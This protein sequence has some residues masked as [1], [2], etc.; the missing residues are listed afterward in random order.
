MRT[1]AMVGLLWIGSLPI[2]VLPARA[3]V[4]GGDSP[5]YCTEKVAITRDLT[6]TDRRARLPDGGANC[7]GPVAISNSM[8]ALAALG[9]P[10][11][12]PGLP[13]E[14]EA[15]RAVARTLAGDGYTA[16]GSRRGTNVSR[17]I[18][19]ANRY[20]TEQGYSARF[21]FQGWRAVGAEHRRGQY[22]D[23]QWIADRLPGPR[24]AWFNIGWYR[25]DEET[26]TYHRGGGHWV[27]AVGYGID[28]RG[29]L[30]PNILIIYDPSPRSGYRRRAD[31]VRWHRLDSGRLAGPDWVPR[32]PGLAR[33]LL[34]LGGG[35][36]INRR[37]GDTALLDGVL[38]MTLDPP[39]DGARRSAPSFD[40][41]AL[42]VGRPLGHDRFI[43]D[44]RRNGDSLPRMEVWKMAD[45]AGRD[46]LVS[47]LP[48]E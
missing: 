22:P 15:H 16:A 34:R 26:D 45:L 37:R 9:Y 19:G 2:G 23:P 18:R 12:V 46:T 33:G 36:E 3:E 31:Y 47:R 4:G 29:R 1:Y 24:A 43:R 14:D 35:L 30:D 13:C 48:R 32:Q 42:H 6:Q 41:A 17:M 38:V 21:E 11:L 27:T 5:R 40:G 8:F 39:G 10:R 20:V 44:W 25:Y 7:C 28:A